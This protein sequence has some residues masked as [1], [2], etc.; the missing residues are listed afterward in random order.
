MQKTLTFDT[1]YAIVELL[2]K[3]VVSSLFNLLFISF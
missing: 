3:T 2:E 1:I